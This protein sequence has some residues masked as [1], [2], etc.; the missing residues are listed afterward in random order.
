MTRKIAGRRGRKT[1]A[2]LGACSPDGRLSNSEIGA[3][4]VSGGRQKEARTS[5]AYLETHD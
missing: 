3:E 2:I 1:I 4:L 5:E